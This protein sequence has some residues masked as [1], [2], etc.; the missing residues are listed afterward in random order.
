MWLVE[1][2]DGPALSQGEQGKQQSLIGVVWLCFQPLELDPSLFLR[3]SET[4]IG[5]QKPFVALGT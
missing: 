2:E 1:S 4:S 5:P 3:K